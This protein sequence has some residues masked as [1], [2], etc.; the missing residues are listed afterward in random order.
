MINTLLKTMSLRRIDA[1]RRARSARQ[2]KRQPLLEASDVSSEGRALIKE[3]GRRAAYK[4]VS[5]AKKVSS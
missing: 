5:W 2:K 1:A 3:S 4:E